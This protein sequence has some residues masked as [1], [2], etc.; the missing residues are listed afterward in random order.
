MRTNPSAPRREV[1]SLG[2]ITERARAIA[3]IASVHR[4]ISVHFYPQATSTPWTV[5]VT[6]R[7]GHR[8]WDRT[9]GSG[10]LPTGTD[11]LHGRSLADVLRLLLRD[12][13]ENLD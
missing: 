13:V 11:T 6:D 3:E 4:E 9:V 8:R 1:P 5:I 2:E 12:A 7:K 10:A